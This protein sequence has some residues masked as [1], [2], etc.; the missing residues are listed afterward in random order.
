MPLAKI[1]ILAT[2]LAL[3]AAGC[4]GGGGAATVQEAPPQQQALQEVGEMYRI[5]QKQY[6]RPPAKVADLDAYSPA[7]SFGS[8]GVQGGSVV[9][10]WGAG[11]TP[12]EP[13]ARGVLAHEKQ[14]ARDGGYVLLQDGTVLALTA[15]GF[16]EAPKAQP[17]PK[18][19]V[20]N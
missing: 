7:F 14:A 9:V 1:R 11:L 19:P 4:G 5:Y 15:A 20:A 2:L 13:G 6:R 17:A 10:R 12:G 8:L 3:V 18:P 16:A